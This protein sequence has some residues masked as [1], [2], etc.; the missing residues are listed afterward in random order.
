MRPPVS[1]WH[2][3][4]D[5]LGRCYAVSDAC[6]SGPSVSPS[7]SPRDL[8]IALLRDIHRKR[9]MSTTDQQGDEDLNTLQLT[10]ILFHRNR[11]SNHRTR[12]RSLASHDQISFPSSFWVASIIW[13]LVVM[14][15]LWMVAAVFAEEK[16][17]NVDGGA[18]VILLRSY[19]AEFLQIDDS[20]VNIRILSSIEDLPARPSTT[21]SHV[22][23]GRPVGRVTF[24]IGTSRVMADVQAVKDV[25]VANRFLRR[26]QILGEDDLRV[27]SLRLAWSDVRYLENPALG[28]GKRVTR[29]VP[30]SLPLTEDVLG[31]PYIIRHGSR[32]TIQYLNGPLKI[33]A[34]GV[35]KDDGAVG[36]YI[37]VANLD[38]RREVWARIIDGE[39]VQVGPNQ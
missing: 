4:L 10:S 29:S 11:C 19:V 2:L 7:A 37:R 14:V 9:K 27:S 12:R 33:L 8:R 20:A 17:Q 31:E 39:T 15:S 34:V 25:V 18:V 6:V 5:F 21:I 32:I 30:S 26:N 28:V 16:K 35:A 13:C 24:L 36:G 1:L 22:G 3:R 23:S 38:S